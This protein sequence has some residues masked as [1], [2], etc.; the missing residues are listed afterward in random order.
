MGNLN[1]AMCVASTALCI[2]AY[3]PLDYAIQSHLHC[4]C[5]KLKIEEYFCSI[6]QTTKLIVFW[7]VYFQ[8]V[9]IY[10]R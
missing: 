3:L 5:M 4:I 1:G 2:Q 8:F 10:F 9:S 6:K 7:E